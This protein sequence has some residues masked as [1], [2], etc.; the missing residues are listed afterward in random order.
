MELSLL[1]NCNHVE[2]GEVEDSLMHLAQKRSQSTPP[3]KQQASPPSS[4]CSSQALLHDEQDHIGATLLQNL[5]KNPLRAI[6]EIRSRLENMKSDVGLMDCDAYI[7]VPVAGKAAKTDKCSPSML[8]SKHDN[9]HTNETKMI[10]PLVQVKAFPINNN[11]SD[12]NLNTSVPQQQKQDGIEVSTPPTKGGSSVFLTFQHHPAPPPPRE[13]QHV[14][15]RAATTSRRRKHPEEDSPLTSSLSASSEDLA[16]APKERRRGDTTPH[17]H[18]NNNTKRRK[19]ACGFPGCGKTF[20]QTNHLQAHRRLHTGER[21]FVCSFDGCNK[22]FTQ[23]GHLTAHLRI[24]TGERPYACSFPGCQK[25]FTQSTNMRM[26]MKV[27]GGMD[28]SSPVDTLSGG[29]GTSSGGTVACRF[30]GCSRMF[31]SRRGMETHM[32]SVHLAMMAAAAANGNGEDDLCHPHDEFQHTVHLRDRRT[33][34]YN[35]RQRVVDD[36]TEEEDCY[37]DESCT[38]ASD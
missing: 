34:P 5:N 7:V 19:F 23:T 35:P 28:G 15:V 37:E 11:K 22:A 1:V 27:H 21:P 4:V 25:R 26:H 31:G 36:D 2:C 18:N 30:A 20:G 3:T 13:Q 16:P 10:K 9:V 32:R 12:D 38:S 6:Y 33:R 14:Q 17:H 29:G 24:H 8:R